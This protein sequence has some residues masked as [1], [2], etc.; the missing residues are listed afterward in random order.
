LLT[1]GSS[2]FPIKTADLK[3]LT[4][5]E[6]SSDVAAVNS[7]EYSESESLHV[8]ERKK[9][10]PRLPHVDGMTVVTIRIERI[11]LKEA[12]QYIEPY[13]SVSVKDAQ[14][15]DLTPIQDTPLPTEREDQCIIFNTNVEIQQY[16]EKLPRTAA[17]FF[18]FKHYKPKKKLTSTKCFAFMEMDEIKQGP[19]CLEIYRKPTDFKRKRLGLLTTKP[20]YLHL[21]LILHQN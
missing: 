20:L 7:V 14:A 10:R 21:N 5:E 17:V 3:Q 18:E 12:L 16:L 6:D 11:G 13:I 8:K 15:A 2:K 19:A 1:A 9:L 4:D